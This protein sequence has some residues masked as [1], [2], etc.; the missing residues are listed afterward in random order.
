VAEDGREYHLP[1]DLKNFEGE[2]LTVA[3]DELAYIDMG[4]PLGIENFEG[5]QRDGVPAGNRIFRMPYLDEN[6]IMT[7]QQW[8]TRS[9]GVDYRIAPRE[10]KIE[11]FTWSM[12][13]DIAFGFVTVTARLYYQKL[14]KPVADFLKVPADESE[15]ILINEAST[16]IEVYD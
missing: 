3:S 10:T 13:D 14:V 12:P 16:T 2:N 11:H 1:V 15:A 9:L 8:N 4:V 7:I 6:G 5:V